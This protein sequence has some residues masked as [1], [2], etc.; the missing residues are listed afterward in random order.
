MLEEFT[1]VENAANGLWETF[2]T[3]PQF[4]SFKEFLKYSSESNNFPLI[5]SMPFNAYMVVYE[6]LMF[7]KDFFLHL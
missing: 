5:N 4:K 2:Y 1:S 6:S 3:L 7:S